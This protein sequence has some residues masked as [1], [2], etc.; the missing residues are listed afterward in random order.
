[1]KTLKIMLLVIITGL[2][3]TSVSAQT[4]KIA[5]INIKVSSQC[6]ECKE[7]IEKA[8]AFE[9]GIKSASVDLETNTVKVTYRTAKTSPENIRKAISE[10]GYDADD[11]A[12]N[13]KSY[14][15]LSDCCKKPDDRKFDH[16]G[17]KH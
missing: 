11:I 15:N 2:T 10:A 13:P 9:K 8:L 3:M 6:N 4:E 12:A 17:H 7:T 1:M 16:S 14:E 5:E